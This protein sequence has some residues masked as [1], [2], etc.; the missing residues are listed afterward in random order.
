MTQRTLMILQSSIK[1]VVT[2]KIKNM[3]HG[4]SNAYLIENET[5]TLPKVIENNQIISR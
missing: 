2:K 1:T 4:L 3:M 5:T